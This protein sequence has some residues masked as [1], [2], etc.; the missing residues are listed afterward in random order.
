MKLR[1]V[2]LF[3]V[4]V[5]AVVWDIPLFAATAVQQATE[6]EDK[7]PAATTAPSKPGT[8][9][10]SKRSTL[11]SKPS[12]L[13]VPGKPSP[14][15][16]P[17]KPSVPPV[18]GKPSTLPVPGKPSAP[19]VP[20][21]PSPP[22]VPG[23]PSAPSSPAQR[24]PAPTKAPSSRVSINVLSPNGG[25][26]LRTGDTVKVRWRARGAS[27]RGD[28]LLQHAGRTVAKIAKGVNLAA[29]SVSWRVNIRKP[30]GG[31]YSIVVRSS[32]GKTKDQSD[33][34]FTILATAASRPGGTGTTGGG[35]PSG[36]G[37]AP[38]SEE[39][40][41]PA[42]GESEQ[43]AVPATPEIVI[44][45][46]AANAAWCTNAPHEFHWTATLPAGTN[47]KIDLM[48]DNGTTVWESVTPSTVNSGSFVWPGLTDAQFASGM[49]YLRP[50]I[51]ATDGSVSKTG[52]LLFFGKPL[53]LSKP[54]STYT[55]RKGMQYTIQWVQLCDLPAPLDID[56]LDSAH[57]PVLNIASGLP[58]GGG[59][60]GKS[61]L[62]TVPTDLTPGTYYIRLRTSGGGLSVEGSFHV[63]EPI[64]IPVSPAITITAPSAN[65]GWCT[66]E[67]HEFH[68]SS[69]LPASTNVKIDLMRGDGSTLWQSITPSTANN[70]SFTWPGLTEA[71]FASG[72]IT[73]RPRI[74]TL[75]N[76]ELTVGEYMHFGRWLM[77]DKPKSNYTWR[78][79]SQY[80]ITWMQP[81]N[82]TST[83]TLELLN[84]AHQPVSTIA[85]GLSTSGTG[86]GKSYG[87]TVPA[88]LVPGVYYIRV[89]T[90][91]GQ[92]SSE[93]SFNVAPPL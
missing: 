76:S 61:M 54:Q 35:T 42:G 21:K 86:S 5:I 53:R 80:T 36:S 46:P 57:Q 89:R 6:D 91:D 13:P 23:K 81:C 56:L 9:V 66:G 44:T 70:G 41:A 51:S 85:T 19:L 78:Q 38:T 12:T 14:L 33:R 29:G 75:D 49:I 32:D 1:Q 39:G 43:P 17:G 11:P 55:W 20:G 24:V 79:G 22:P 83:V 62:W 25:E 48:R 67:P 74:S 63:A 3:I 31:G 87:W 58:V 27:G 92:H 60:S 73:V 15:P 34:P 7:T 64:N 45:T 2:A 30:L 93:G 18:P 88:G 84:S 4:V 59:S 8:P 16:V 50:R 65:V 71:Q 69:T 90:A 82:L 72:M 77:L 68:W 28:V 37:T 52:D 47:V 26:T 40:S 10:P